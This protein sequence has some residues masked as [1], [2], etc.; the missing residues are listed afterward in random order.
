VRHDRSSLADGYDEY[1]GIGHPEKNPDGS[2]VMPIRYS[3]NGWGTPMDAYLPIT[4]RLVSGGDNTVTLGNY[5]KFLATE[6]KLLKNA[7]DSINAKKTLD[8][9]F[10]A[11]Q[12]LRRLDKSA[13]LFL[14]KESEKQSL[15]TIQLRSTRDSINSSGF[16]VVDTDGNIIQIPV[17]TTIKNFPKCDSLQMHFG[18]DTSGYSGFFYRSDASWDNTNIG[19]ANHTHEDG[20]WKFDNA[21]NNEDGKKFNPNNPNATNFASEDQIFAL[22]NGLAMVKRMVEPAKTDEEKKVLEQANKQLVGLIAQALKKLEL[23]GCFE[24][25]KVRG[26]GGQLMHKNELMR[27]AKDLGLWSQVV[28]KEPVL[29]IVFSVVRDNEPLE[30]FLASGC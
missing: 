25:G 21:Y 16:P 9:M 1:D 15:D 5:L 2:Y 7:G 19:T 3:K 22:I 4:N 10:L 28:Q 6:Y 29:G 26:N 30:K 8:E 27:V 11:Q 13:N 12:A 20:F 24:G 23:K 18:I 14:L 17:T